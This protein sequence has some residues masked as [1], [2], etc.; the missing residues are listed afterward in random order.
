MGHEAYRAADEREL[1][2]GLTF[3]GLFN[4]PGF[5]RAEREAVA[6]AA[7]SNCAYG[8]KKRT[9]WGVGGKHDDITALVVK[10]D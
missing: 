2:S 9:P 7:A 1:A 10:V 4:T 6:R 8:A 3:L 5:Q